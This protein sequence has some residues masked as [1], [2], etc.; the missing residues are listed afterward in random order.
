MRAAIRRL[1]PSYLPA[2]WFIG[3]MP[4]LG[5]T[6]NPLNTRLKVLGDAAQ[7]VFE[8][9]QGQEDSA[10]KFL[11]RSRDYSL[12]LTA[13]E[14][15]LAAGNNAQM[16]LTFAGSQASG[17]EGVDPLP[18]KVN[19]FLGNDPSR[20]LHNI[21]S[22]SRV[23]YR[24]VY[25][26]VDLEYRITGGQLAAEFQIAPN[27]DVAAL[28]LRLQ[29]AG[30]LVISATGEL[31]LNPGPSEV[32]ILPPQVFE[33]SASGSRKIDGHYVLDGDGQA[34]IRVGSRNF[35]HSLTIDVGFECSSCSLVSSSDYRPAVGLDAS[36]RLY[37]AEQIPLGQYNYGDAIGARRETIAVRKFDETGNQTA[38]VTYVG[39]SDRDVVTG[40][41][42][43]KAGCAYLVGYTSSRDFPNTPGAAQTALAGRQNAFVTKIDTDGSTLAYSTY[44]GGEA[45]DLA[46]GVAV[47]SIGAAYVTG[48]SDSAGFP[49]TVTG[50]RSRTLEGDVFVTK[51]T[52]AGDKLEYSTTVGGGSIETGRAITVDAGG[53]AY[54]T[55]FTLSADFPV[56]PGATQE[57]RSHGSDA[58]LFSLDALG[59]ALSFG[60]YLGGDD[61]DEGTAVA[62]DDQGKVYVAGSTRSRNFL[63]AA[64]SFRLPN[65]GPGGGFLAVIEP[66]RGN[67]SLV[68]YLDDTAY[69]KAPFVLHRLSGRFVIVGTRGVA[70][71]P[72]PSSDPQSRPRSRR[73]FYQVEIRLRRPSRR[74]SQSEGSR[75]VWRLILLP[76]AVT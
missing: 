39:G 15:V 49:V 54:V 9:N 38:Y 34:A 20:W 62:V 76:V 61:T 33:P 63:G 67:Q 32:R 72:Q 50:G 3:I 16:R 43:D 37:V 4:V 11:F 19:Y 25:P 59:S 64:A 68:A 30:K 47:D 48:Y 55:G 1:P 65:S 14:A 52:T 31:L 23:R 28:R 24:G 36:G 13:Q 22:F 53:N 8:S 74:L 10:V 17:V 27:A 58:F 6:P 66:N 70:A 18:A 7:A 12:F 73:T 42:I 29:G 26:G 21:S 5:Q 51:L 44:L 57:K 69:V 56:T 2:L 75:L 46:F 35:G 41:A 40:L 60:T 45:H 71:S